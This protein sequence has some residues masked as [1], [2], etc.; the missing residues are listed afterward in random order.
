MLTQPQGLRCK[1]ERGKLSDLF[2]E[3][4]EKFVNGKMRGVRETEESQRRTMVLDGQGPQ[5]RRREQ[6]QSPT[7]EKRQAEVRDDLL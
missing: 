1:I 4:D 7:L 2:A 3:R 6:Q 5:S